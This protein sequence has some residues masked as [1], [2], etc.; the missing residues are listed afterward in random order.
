MAH[1]E[2]N[3]E[4]REISSKKLTTEKSTC[5]RGRLNK[6]KEIENNRT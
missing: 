2:T 1:V 5:F 3:H 4:G 6:I